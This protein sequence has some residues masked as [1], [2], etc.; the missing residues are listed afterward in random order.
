MVLLFGVDIPLI[1]IIVI[2]F[3][4]S[5]LVLVEIII[6]MLILTK[7]L[8]KAKQRDELQKQMMDTLLQIKSKEIEELGRIRRK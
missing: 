6:V 7:M 8:E 4:L 3:I 5:F 1:Q 2:F